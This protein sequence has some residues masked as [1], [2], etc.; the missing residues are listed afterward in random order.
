MPALEYIMV[1]FLLSHCVT[2]SEINAI[3]CRYLNFDLWLSIYICMCV[4][5]WVCGCV[6]VCVCMYIKISAKRKI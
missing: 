4:W 1:N 5:V 3:K 2:T 6:C